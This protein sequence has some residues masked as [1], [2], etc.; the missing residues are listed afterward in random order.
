MKKIL[1]FTLFSGVILTAY[2]S[3]YYRGY[4]DRS[5]TLTALQL[6][7]AE[8]LYTQME[9]GRTDAAREG[10]K[11]VIYSTA[12]SYRKLE[13]SPFEYFSREFSSAGSG[14]LAKQLQ[15]ADEITAGMTFASPAFEGVTRDSK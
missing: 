7:T 8:A 11:V 4:H 13:Q 2:G 6:D 5:R 14:D 12:E 3:G 15:R 10:L 9:Q 1:F